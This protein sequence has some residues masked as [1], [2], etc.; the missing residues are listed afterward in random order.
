VTVSEH[1]RREL[2]ELLGADPDR[3]T[4]VRP[5][6]DE[7]FTPGADIERSR[8][9]LGLTRPYVL[10]VA[11]HGARKNLPALAT[12]ARRLRAEGL[13]LVVA[14]G[15]R[16]HLA[17]DSAVDGA[18]HVGYVP[19]EHLPGL[20]AG[21]SAFVLPSRHEGFGLP[22]IE[23]MASGTPVVASNRGALPETCGDAALLVD[24][25]DH[26]A[27]ADA[28]LSAALDASAAQRLRRAGLA[29][30]ATLS[31]ERAA[32]EVD[33]VLRDAASSDQGSPPLA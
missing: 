16:A 13:E 28:V 27:I 25:D 24:P 30:A 15:T 32:R 20:Y 2:V 23:A 14:G 17:A 7:R 22:C 26:D 3:I 21:A 9:A 4:V 1:S 18:R 12:A 8:A 31:W 19:E 10:T 5:G 11:A 6:V 33:A 29:R